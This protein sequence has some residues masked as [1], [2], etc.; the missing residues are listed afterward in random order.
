MYYSLKTIITFYIVKYCET[1]HQNNK[2][3]TYFFFNINE[4]KLYYVLFR[5]REIIA[6]RQ[7]IIA[8]ILEKKIID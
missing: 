8:S 1:R 4:F 5:A 6:S 7:A 2:Y 3:R